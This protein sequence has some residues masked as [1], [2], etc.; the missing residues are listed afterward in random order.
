M[1]K[2]FFYSAIILAIS[3]FAILL[4]SVAVHIEFGIPWGWKL[5]GFAGL[6]FICLIIL[7][8]V[9]GMLGYW[10]NH[11]RFGPSKYMMR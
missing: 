1:K 4:I 2:I 6:I 3:I 10:R 9:L 5:I 7:M 11:P 8:P